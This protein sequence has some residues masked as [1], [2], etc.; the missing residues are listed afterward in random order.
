M[1]RV[2]T[3]DGYALQAEAHGRG[4]PLILSCGLCT[5]LEHWRGQI[6]PFVRAG[7]RVILWDYRGHGRTD[8]PDDPDAYSLELVLD[9]LERVLDWAA[10]GEPAVLGGL[11]FG[12]LASMHMALARPERVRALV[13]AATGPGFK[14]PEAQ[15]RWAATMEKTASL[16]ERRGMEALLARPMAETVIGLRPELPAAQA[17]ARALAAQDPRGVAHFLRRLGAPARPVVD[18][19]EDIGHP[20]LVVVG[21]LDGAFLHAA[22]LM[23]ARLPRVERSTIADAG[24]IVNI[25][26]ADAF[27]AAVLAFLEKL[28]REP[29]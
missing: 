29:G 13:L 25:E 20:A 10:P 12:G 19:L 8:A 28:E 24:H 21:A 16:L 27:D 9:D 6:E 23:Q 14:R 5:T 1:A 26:Q 18:R 7:L 3:C 17:A 15:V 22:D 4:T 11:S 2:T